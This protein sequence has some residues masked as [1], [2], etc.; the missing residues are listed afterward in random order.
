MKT[1]VY[2][3]GSAGRGETD[4]EGDSPSKVESQGNENKV[5]PMEK[6]A[7]RDHTYTHTLYKKTARNRTRY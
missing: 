7:R 5:K 1:S 4:C 3:E 2:V 6:D